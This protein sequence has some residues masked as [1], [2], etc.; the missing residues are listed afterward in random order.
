MFT[1]QETK[2]LLEVL[3][4]ITISPVQPNAVEIMASL[5]TIMGK[6]QPMEEPKK[7]E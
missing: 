4:K 5:Q 2:L 3:S 6:L 7:D 1:E